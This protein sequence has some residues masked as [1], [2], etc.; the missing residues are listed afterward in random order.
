MART[1]L[2]ATAAAVAL[3]ATACSSSPKPAASS[4]PPTYTQ[5]L[6]YAQCMRTH[7]APAY[8]DPVQGPG[9]Y[10]AFLSTPGSEVGNPPAAAAKACQKLAPKQGALPPS[11]IQAARERGLKLATCM[12][13]HG[14]TNFP[15]PV[16]SKGGIGINLHGLDQNS[17]QF[18][19]AQQACQAYRLG[20]KGGGGL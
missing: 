11:V 2:A 13:A 4:S 1:A 12:R 20:P 18:Q 19:A 9:G 14:I 16:V 7:G 6:T 8:P 5:L 10:W 3:L 15:D 17:P